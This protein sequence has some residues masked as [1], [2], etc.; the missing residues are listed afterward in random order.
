MGKKYNDRSLTVQVL[1]LFCLTAGYLVFFWKLFPRIFAWVSSIKLNRQIFS[2]LLF[3]VTLGIMGFKII[4]PG[5]I[6]G[7]DIDYH[8]LRIESLRESI[9]L[10]QIPARVNPIFL[11]GY[12]YASSLFYPDIFLYIPAA[13]SALGF[14]TILSAKIF[15][16]LIF[17]FCFIS[18][19]WA[20]KQMMGSQDA[21]LM[22]AIIYCLSQY[23]L[24]NVYRRGALGEM[25]AFIF[26]PLIVY[27]LYSLIFERFEKYWVMA[28]G[29]IGL[30]YSHLISA[31][32]AAMLVTSV[33]LLHVRAIFFDKARVQR[34]VKF[35]ILTLGST[36]A[37]WLPLI[38]QLSSGS[39]RF[40]QS[41][42]LARYSALPLKAIFAVTGYF[43]GNFVA[44]GLPTL[45]LCLSWFVARKRDD[46]DQM[47]RVSAWGLGTGAVLLLIVSNAF[48]WNWINGPLNIIQ[49]PWRLYSF[50]GMF[51]AV[52]AS[53]M[54]NVIIPHDLRR[55]GIVM[56]VAF[57][58]IHAIWVINDSGSAPRDLPLDFYRQPANTFLINNAEWLPAQTDLEVLQT[59]SPVILDNKSQNIPFSRFGQKFLIEPVPECIYLDIPAIFYMGYS[60]IY[61]DNAGNQIDLP[62]YP[63]LPDY[64]VRVDCPQNAFNGSIRFT[65]SGTFLQQASLLANLLFVIALTILYRFKIHLFY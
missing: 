36:I 65:Y 49:F 7:Y 26:L 10:G 5:M 33:G 60:A 34:I 30:L 57:L 14:S 17:C 59:R 29:F 27:G 38:E 20:G 40:S 55:I 48:P 39:F 2:V 32:I 61:S 51:L 31:L 4:K 9:R 15:F 56:L 64:T 23:L 21:G 3:L 63:V 16:L 24:Q 19:Y 58:G 42:Y 37:F 35:T 52:A 44:F 8:M 11:N 62:I 13:L 46:E 45:L 25:Q 53:A 47:Q 18:A 6:S 43:S 50:A 28:I 12:G 22:T 41:T 1:I 54:L